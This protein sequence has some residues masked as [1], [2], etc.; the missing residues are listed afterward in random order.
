MTSLDASASIGERLV[1]IS[2]HHDFVKQDRSK[3]EPSSSIGIR[4]KTFIT[5]R[6]PTTARARENRAGMFQNPRPF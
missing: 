6:F 3:I 4:E 2:I 1:Q 5:S